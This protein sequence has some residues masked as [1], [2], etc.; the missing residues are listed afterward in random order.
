MIWSI[1]GITSLLGA[2][3]AGRLASR[4][5]IG[6]T[7]TAGLLF[8]GLG[9]LLTPLAH[10]ATWLSGTLLVL[11]QLISDPAHTVYN[12]NEL[13]L[14]QTVTPERLQGRVNATLE[15]L[16]LGAT[17]LG[18]M[19]GG[20]LGQKIGLR[21]TVVLGTF[22]AFAAA[23]WLWLSPVCRVTGLTPSER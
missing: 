8:A 10:G 3:A 21:P 5:G 16:S 6:R 19:L 9:T 20:I 4:I 2:L 7:M 15:F 22:G 14:R 23:L 11:T 18:A 13:S 1:G 17:L 12:I